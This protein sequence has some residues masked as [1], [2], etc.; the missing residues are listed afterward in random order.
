MALYKKQ[1]NY[2]YRGIFHVHRGS[3]RAFRGT[4]RV[5]R[6]T[7][8]AHRRTSCTHRR[9]TTAPTQRPSKC[10]Q[11]WG[12]HD[13][14]QKIKIESLG[15]QNM[16]P[17]IEI[18]APGFIQTDATWELFEK[19][20]EPKVIISLSFCWIVNYWCVITNCVVYYYFFIPLL[21]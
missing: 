11:D 1:S 12:A 16:P 13:L 17:K 10:P 15:T 18:M 5:H 19:Y 7:Y 6:G 4:A 3:V 8:H 20:S 9:G 21:T 14:F 2:V